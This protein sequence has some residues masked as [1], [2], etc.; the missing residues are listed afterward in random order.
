MV[1]QK[2]AILARRRAAVPSTGK[3]GSVADKTRCFFAFLA[4][5]DLFGVVMPAGHAA[6]EPAGSSGGGADNVP[7]VESVEEGAHD[8]GCFGW[9]LVVVFPCE[10]KQMEDREDYHFEAD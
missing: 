5:E 7:R 10:C 2:S 8:W 6:D 1:Y 9:S 3:A 4:L